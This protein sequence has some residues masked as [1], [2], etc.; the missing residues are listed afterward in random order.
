[1]N[2]QWAMAAPLAWAVWGCAHR[3]DPAIPIEPPGAFSNRGGA[4][5]PDRWWTALGDESLDRLVDAALTGN[6]DIETAWQRLAEARAVAEREG[7][8]LWPDVDA[9]AEAAW[10]RPD[11]GEHLRLGLAAEYEIDLWGELRSRKDAARYRA[12]ASLDDHQTAA[13]TVSAEVARVWYQ[14]V[15]AHNQ[16]DLLAR[17]IETNETVLQLLLDQYG[18]GQVRSVDILR[19][20]R[21][22]QSTRS[23][24]LLVEA[25]IGV[26]EH[27]LLVLLGRPPQSDIEAHA[28]GRALPALPPLPAA[29]LPAEL[30]ERRPDV[31]AVYHRVR[32]TDADMAAAIANRYPRLSLSA[33]I[34][35]SE[36][37]ASSLFRD[38]FASLAANLVG[39]LIDGGERAA[40]VDRTEAIR[41]QRLA[42][43]G[44]TALTA[45]R[46]VEDALI[47]EAKQAALIDNIESQV[48]L[49]QSTYDQLR[50]EYFNGQ[51]DYIDVLDTLTE[52]Q[53]L[54][55][56]L[57]TARRLLLEYRIA[58]YRSLAGG[59][60]RDRDQPT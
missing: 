47:L 44:Q 4:A 40:E 53:Q 58:L 45:F 56:D 52:L 19:Q 41:R 29:G 10:T 15:E 32:A 34:G 50:N 23:Q 28:A 51:S 42:E 30:I 54:R 48:E 60:P 26:L 38:W 21:L 17:Q 35:T 46:E 6:F 49:A 11:R 37:S 20:R 5:V 55:R 33:S 22:V 36:G 43:Y 1:M 25:R 16:R 57:L 18:G 27:R 9:F 59:F 14:L 31:R 7:A 24:V 8:D 12:L 13:L 2:S 39:P 3:A